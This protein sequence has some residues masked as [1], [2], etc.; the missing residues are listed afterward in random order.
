MILD[1]EF[2]KSYF[3]FYKISII[4]LVLLVFIKELMF[5]FNVLFKDKYPIVYKN[6]DNV[7]VT[8]KSDHVI[9]YLN[10]ENDQ[11]LSFKCNNVN[12]G[13][14]KS[15]KYNSINIKYITITR[16]RGKVT[17]DIHYLIN[18]CTRKQCFD[19]QSRKFINEQK[20]QIYSQ[21]KVN[22]GLILGIVIFVLA[23]PYSYVMPYGY[24]KK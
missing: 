5:S 23:I 11:T 22:F 8:V 1:K 16:D 2:F 19:N 7:E 9:V 20:G 14:A 12:C 6:N 17:E 13:L 10:Q 3:I 15:G 24:R 21:A 18:I 4:A